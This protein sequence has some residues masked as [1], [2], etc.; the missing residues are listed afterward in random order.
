MTWKF[1][2]LPTQGDFEDKIRF[3]P[4]LSDFAL[5][6]NVYRDDWETPYD[7]ERSYY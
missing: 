3:R 4:E 6:I 1:E 5:S 7:L 2:D